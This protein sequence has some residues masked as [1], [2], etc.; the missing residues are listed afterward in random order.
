LR[1]ASSF[2]GVKT[3]K[4]DKVGTGPEGSLEGDRQLGEAKWVDKMSYYF[5]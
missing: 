2:A 4:R 3:E 1:K 5:G